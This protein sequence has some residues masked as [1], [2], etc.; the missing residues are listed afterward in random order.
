MQESVVL[1]I[2]SFLNFEG[3]KDNSRTPTYLWSC[4]SRWA[5]ISLRARSTRIS[6]FSWISLRTTGSYKP[7]RRELGEKWKVTYKVM[8]MKFHEVQ[9]FTFFFAIKYQHMKI[10][11]AKFCSHKYFER[12]AVTGCMTSWMVCIAADDAVK[13]GLLTTINIYILH[14]GTACLICIIKVI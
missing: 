10:C 8:S 5:V 4:P 14:V 7:L 2:V 1:S 9:I 6:L 3:P 11:T 12:E 13:S